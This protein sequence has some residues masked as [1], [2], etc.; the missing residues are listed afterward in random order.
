MSPEKHI[1]IVLKSQELK[2][3]KQVSPSSPSY[4]VRHN[5]TS[6]LFPKHAKQERKIIQEVSTK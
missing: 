3:D 4:D 5:K 6:P 2:K 1:T